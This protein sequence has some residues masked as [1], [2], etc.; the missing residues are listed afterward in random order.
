M[1]WLRVLAIYFLVIG[2]AIVLMG[3]LGGVREPI[4]ESF[5]YEFHEILPERDVKYVSLTSGV[6]RISIISEAEAYVTIY[7]S[8]FG[9]G[10]EKLF[11][12]VVEG[13][14]KLEFATDVPSSYYVYI[15][16]MPTN[17]L[18]NGSRPRML[19][20]ILVEPDYD[21]TYV[22]GGPIIGVGV[23]LLL[24]DRVVA[25]REASR[26]LASGVS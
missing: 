8:V 25:R 9:G 17:E 26:F 23:A 5:L 6:V 12:R 3:V 16:L 20:D 11:E 4:S 7:R 21:F 18:V 1:I 2:V 13:L 10:P 24:L 15:E 22:F 14:E 19:L